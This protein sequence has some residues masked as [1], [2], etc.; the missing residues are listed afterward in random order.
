MFFGK[1]FFVLQIAILPGWKYEKKKTKYI[2]VS[3]GF[4]FSYKFGFNFDFFFFEQEEGI[5]VSANCLFSC[6]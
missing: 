1:H 4:L 2:E 3:L 5:E 6:E